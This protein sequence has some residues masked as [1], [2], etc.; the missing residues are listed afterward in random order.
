MG[1]IT[2][3]T[4]AQLST[5]PPK[6]PLTKGYKETQKQ[7]CGC[8]GKFQKR[9]KAKAFTNSLVYQ[10]VQVD[11]RLKKSYWNSFHCSNIQIQKGDEISSNYCNNRWCI[12]CNRI[13]TA[14]MII[15]YSEPLEKLQNPYFVTLTIPNVKGKLL[16]RSIENMVDS[17]TRIRK[18]IKKTH[19]LKLTGIRKTECTYNPKRDDYHPHFHLIIE[20]K[21]E[22][23]KLV[24]MW[25]QQYPQATKEAQDVKKAKEG[26]TKEI[27]KYFTKL[28]NKDVFYAKNMDVIFR[29]MYRKRVFQPI[30]IKKDVSED[31]DEI[32]TQKIDFKEPRSEK[33]EW[34]DACYDWVNADGETLSDYTPSDKTIKF[35]DKLKEHN[36]PKTH[37]TE[38]QKHYTI[39][40]DN[41]RTKEVYSRDL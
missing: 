5:T 19:G 30:G 7:G 21:Q 22:A 6:P 17:F 29:A 28:I 1:T 15:G 2:L 24:D 16:K 4:L 33:W 37:T 3:D 38:H 18:N 39:S 36:E 25:L 8:K 34:V 31:I 14:K 41:Q 11:S 13:R 26:T 12:V 10:L 23:N 35:I 40:K 27:F 32:Q 9:A 20:G